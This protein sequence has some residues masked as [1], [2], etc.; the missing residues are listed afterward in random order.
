[1][2]STHRTIIGQGLAGTCLAWELWKR[3]VPFSIVDRENGGSS[4]VAA[5]L[6]NPVTGKNF[7]PSQSIA[8][9]L[10]Q[11]MDF[12]AEIESI[13]GIQ[14]WFPHPILRLAASDK[15]WTKM[16]LKAGQADVA[17]WLSHDGKLLE[18]D[19][20]LGA[21]KVHSGGRVDTRS[22][23]DH[24]REFFRTS[25]HYQ[26]AHISIDQAPPHTI[27]CEGAVGL[28]SG[29]YGP[30]RCAK[31]EILSISATGWNENEIRIGAGGWLV[32]I[33]NGHFKVGS[34]YEWNQLDE[35]P[36]AQGLETITTI[37]TRLGG[38]DFE[39]IHHEAG[40]RPIFRRSEP[41]IG[42]IDNDQWMFNALG[43][44]GSLYAPGIARQLANWL[45]DGT[46]PDPSYR[47][48]KAEH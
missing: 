38:P 5:G 3:Q 34:T 10:P 27:W 48:A 42:P 29:R 41:L 22:F 24:S 4:R 12:Y 43:S 36:S 31:G 47:W 2:S 6:I 33:G 14:I 32:P 18:I 44:K 39:I 40:I 26:Q 28:I 19:G 7:E 9:F 16:Q 45:I 30:H 17:R 8:T 21:I 20:W 13:L 35:T 37:A 1:M 25:G 46:S 11:A 23:L 15:E